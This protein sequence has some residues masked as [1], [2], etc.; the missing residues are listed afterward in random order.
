MAAV[1][2]PN[3]IITELM[4][5]DRYSLTCMTITELMERDG[6]SRATSA[7]CVREVVQ[8]TPTSECV[9]VSRHSHC[10]ITS[11]T[12]TDFSLK[13]TKKPS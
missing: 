5:R 11:Q 8:M 12:Y 1:R 2:F 3:M 7:V 6:Y 13:A 9:L 10:P 4:E